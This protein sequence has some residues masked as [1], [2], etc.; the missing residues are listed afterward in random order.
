MGWVFLS[1][2][3]FCTRARCDFK[4]GILAGYQRKTPI[5]FADFGKQNCVGFTRSILVDVPDLKDHAYLH[6]PWTNL[7]KLNLNQL[8]NSVQGTSLGVSD[9]KGALLFL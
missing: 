1:V 7:K 2:F 3:C 8:T 9:E 4:R 5:Y 6:I